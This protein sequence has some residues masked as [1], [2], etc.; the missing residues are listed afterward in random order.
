[1]CGSPINRLFNYITI[2]LNSKYYFLLFFFLPPRRSE[3]WMPTDVSDVLHDDVF[4]IEGA[5]STPAN[6]VK[7]YVGVYKL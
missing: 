6:V 4:W 1:M 5:F 3:D 7:M 2:I